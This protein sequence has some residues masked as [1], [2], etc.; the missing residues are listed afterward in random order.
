MK[1]NL[2]LILFVLFILSC[3]KNDED[4]PPA[5]GTPL[6]KTVTSD[7]TV[8]RSYWYD[9]QGRITC[10]RAVEDMIIDS[11]VYLY[12]N[13]NLEQKKYHDGNLV[14]IEHGI[15]ENGNLV[16]MN[17]MKADSSSFWSTFYTYDDNGFLFREIH[18]DNDTAETWRVEYQV[19]DGNV[20]SMNRTNYFP[21]VFTFEYYPGTTNSLGFIV[22]G[23]F[24]GKYSKNLIKK[25]MI[26]FSSGASGE[27]DYTYE[28]YENGWVKKMT[29]T[30]ASQTNILYFTY[31]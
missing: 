2:L 19:A 1:T 17:G 15:L 18:M 9:S 8:V 3:S 27:E 5:S 28:Y 24:L 6:I 13:N 22:Q 12:G 16:S 29:V 7:S 31:W 25:T 23:P 20:L 21:V 30:F 14:E 4:T 10:S 11:T 26:A